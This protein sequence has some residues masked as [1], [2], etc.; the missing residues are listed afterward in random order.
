MQY[1]N[2]KLVILT[3]SHIS[4]SDHISLCTLFSSGAEYQPGTPGGAWSQDDLMVVRAK[5]WRLYGQEIDQ[6]YTLSVIFYLLTGQ[7]KG[8]P[9]PYTLPDNFFNKFGLPQSNDF[10]DLQHFAAK[11]V[12]LR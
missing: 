5:L 2:W 8:S 12:R 6:G 11:V 4:A 7:E 9:Y 1:L 10:E 3:K